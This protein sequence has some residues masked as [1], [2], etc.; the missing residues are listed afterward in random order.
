MSN[1]CIFCEIENSTQIQNDYNTHIIDTPHFYVVAGRGQICEG[2][3]IICARQHIYNMSLLSKEKW[4]ELLYLKKK[5]SKMT[6]AIYKC[7]PLFFE[8]GDADC[9]NRGGSCIS[10][11]HIHVVPLALAKEPEMLH[12]FPLYCFDDPNKWK[13]FAISHSPYFY[14]ELANGKI[15]MINETNL[16]CQFGRQLLVLELKLPVNW[17]WR[18][19]TD[20]DK[21]R[22]TIAKCVEYRNPFKASNCL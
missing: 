10:H 11:A 8:H 7:R 3:M 13:D 9:H 17:D 14:L 2:Y 18:S 22:E 4:E 5:I 21:M 15:F 1:E 16:P 12:K 6:E 19:T 20:E